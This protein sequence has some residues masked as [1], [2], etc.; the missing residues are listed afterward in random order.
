MD[1]S[2][3][4][5]LP[6]MPVHFGGGLPLIEMRVVETAFVAIM[7]CVQRPKGPLLMRRG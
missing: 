7:L 6:S 4:S 2:R 1:T 5:G 3:F